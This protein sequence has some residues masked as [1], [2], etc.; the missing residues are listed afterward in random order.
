MVT[1]GGLSL[2]AVSSAL[3]FG[4]RVVQTGYELKAVPEQTQELLDTIQTVTE[5][6]KYAR[7]L[8]R[9]KS[10]HL[11]IREKVHIDGKITDTEKA[12]DGLEALVEAARVDMMTRFGQVG[13]W[14]RALW[15]V[16]AGPKVD[17]TLARLNVAAIALSA[18]VAFM[19]ARD[20]GK[21]WSSMEDNNNAGVGAGMA[22]PP[23]TYET[24][25]FINSRRMK[26]RRDWSTQ[27]QVGNVDATTPASAQQIPDREVADPEGH[28]SSDHP[29]DMRSDYPQH[30]NP[31]NDQISELDGSSMIPTARSPPAEDSSFPPFFH[32]GEPRSAQLFQSQSRS[33]GAPTMPAEEHTQA[34]VAARGHTPLD[35]PRTGG[36]RERLC[37]NTPAS[38]AETP[39][40]DVPNV[41][42]G[43]RLRNK[44]WLTFQADLPGQWQ[45]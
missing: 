1:D 9:Q 13:T 20:G 39:V 28:L 22:S 4:F 35:L 43:R 10:A 24:S 45:I 17:T 40:N 42:G 26:R 18:A 31:F 15:V 14:K 30:L 8:R 29:A 7:G 27:S 21:P 41:P 2:A 12:K 19:S 34:G 33:H 36:L 11:D 37:A 23:P 32:P 16:R 44:S 6:I 25:E 38:R 5:D 3:N